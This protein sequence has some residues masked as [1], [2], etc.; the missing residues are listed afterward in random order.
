M[1]ELPEVETIRR[2]LI[3]L[4][5]G[6]VIRKV[7]LKTPSLLKNYPAKDFQHELTGKQVV[8]FFR[9][10]K[11]LIFHCGEVYP[12]FHLGMSGI[13]LQSKAESRYPQHIHLEM[14]FE[15]GKV[16]YFQDMR[17]F[18]N[19]RLYKEL[20]QFPELGIEPLNGEFTVAK[21][22]EMLCSKKMNIKQFLMSQEY[23]A[24]IGN[25][26]ASEIL[27]EAQISPLRRAFE[28]NDAESAALHRAI[29]TILISSIEKFGT[30]YSAYRTVAGTRGGNQHFLRVYQRAGE[31][32]Y[33]CRGVV[34][35]IVLGSRSTFYCENCQE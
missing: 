20:P 2:Q 15:S 34:R 31:G 19:I 35:K 3:P 9:R 22:A 29:G 6:E 28:L 13:F 30:T 27:F 10:G 18:G 12:V 32:C 7:N 26:Y 5:R 1:P 4:Y 16:L 17:K 25:I 21:L 8:D 11:F 33:R 14:K 23:I 24:G